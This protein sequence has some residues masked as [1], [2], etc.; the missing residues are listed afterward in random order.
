MI[1][2]AVMKYP[3]EN[4]S[5]IPPGF[6]LGSHRDSVWD[7]TWFH[8]DKISGFP[9]KKRDPDINPGGNPSGIPPGYCGIPVGFPPGFTSGSRFFCG[10]PEILSQWNQVG[11][12]LESRWDPKRNP[13]GIPDLFSLGHVGICYKCMSLHFLRE[14]SP[15]YSWNIAARA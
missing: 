15:E 8:R 6:H 13:G 10:N 3:R 12:Q 14:P 7:P 5:G 9:P 1:N 2:A 4:K 11:F